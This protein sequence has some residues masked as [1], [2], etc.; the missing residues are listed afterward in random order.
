MYGGS[1]S[2]PL[3]EAWEAVVKEVEAADPAVSHYA[4]THWSSTHP[5]VTDDRALADELTA[6]LKSQAFMK[7]FL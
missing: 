5:R 4:F 6:W 3:R 2:T 7:R 1:Q